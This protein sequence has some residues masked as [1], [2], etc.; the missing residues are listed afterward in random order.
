MCN[1]LKRNKGVAK[2]APLCP[3]PHVWCSAPAPSMGSWGR[4]VVSSAGGS[5]KFVLRGCERIL[6]SSLI[7]SLAHTHP[8]PMGGEQKGT[9]WGPGPP[10]RGTSRRDPSADLAL[11]TDVELWLFFAPSSWGWVTTFPPL[12]FTGC[13]HLAPCFTSSSAPQCR[14]RQVLSAPTLQPQRK[15]Q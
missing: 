8:R 12:L 14:E 6:W 15:G 13:S 10:T 4:G 3:H 9:C 5:V 11:G 7:G 2:R 1:S